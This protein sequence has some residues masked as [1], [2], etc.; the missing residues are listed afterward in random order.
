MLGCGAMGLWCIQTLRGNIVNRLIAVDTDQGKLDLALRFGATSAVNASRED[1]AEAIS[2]LTD[3]RMADFAIE[4]AG[5]TAQLGQAIRCVRRSRG[6]VI[7]MSSHESAAAAFDFRPAIERS[8]EI[9]VA[10]PSYSANEIDDLR[11]AVGL[12]NEGVFVLDRI[13][14]H[15]FPLQKIQEAFQSLASKPKGFI[16]GIV[17]P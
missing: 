7:L 14:T 8:V 2:A 12:L 10:H 15:T 1:V 3:G 13:V 9:R 17:I 5:I 16:K 11:K 4:G 6:R